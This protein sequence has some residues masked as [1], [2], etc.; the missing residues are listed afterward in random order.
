MASTRRRRR[1]RS[2]RWVG[3]CGASPIAHRRVRRRPRRPARP[4]ARAADDADT[5][6]FLEAFDAF[7][8]EYGSR[9]P[10]EWET[11][12][13]SWETDPDLPLAAIDRMRLADDDQAPRHHQEAMAAARE[14]AMPGVLAAVEDD[15]RRTGS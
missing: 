10:N 11:S 6:G 14:A 4:A 13:P 12:A 1:T 3:W 9:G 7:I 2:G 5:K 8:Y 15:P